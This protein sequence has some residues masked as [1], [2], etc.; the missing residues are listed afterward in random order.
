MLINYGICLCFNITSTGDTYT[1]VLSAFVKVGIMF[2]INEMVVF[3]NRFYETA[4]GSLLTA[5][6]RY[7]FIMICAGTIEVSIDKYVCNTSQ[8]KQCTM[9]SGLPKRNG[10]ST[11]TRQNNRQSFRRFVFTEGHRFVSS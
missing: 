5:D 8:S 10:L 6:E 1:V 3:L 4:H 11:W 7:E 9:F 2:S